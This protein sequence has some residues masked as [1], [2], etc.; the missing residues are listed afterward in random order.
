MT[1]TGSDS[2]T[3]EAERLADTI[4]E[5]A[6]RMA[7]SPGLLYALARRGE[8]R[9]TRLGRRTLVLRSEQARVLAACT[10]A[11]TDNDGK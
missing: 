7:C 10:A 4:P 6:R 2:V 11:S 9:L 5:A 3:G 8:L 1:T